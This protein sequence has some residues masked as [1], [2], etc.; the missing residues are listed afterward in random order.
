VESL[1]LLVYEQ[2]WADYIPQLSEALHTDWEIEASANSSEWLLQRLPDADAMLGLTL[3]P[4]ALPSATQLRA[5]FF[6]GA[7][8]LQRDANE[9]PEGCPVCNVYEHEI[10]I[11]EHVF[12]A[13]LRHVTRVPTYAT[14]FQSGR[15]EGTGRLGGETH[16]ECFGKTIG[17]LGFGHIGQE[18]AKR[19]L[20][21][22]MRVEAIRRTPNSGEDL[23]VAPHFLGGP[24][25]LRCVLKKSDFF[26]VACELTAETRGCLGPDELSLLK[27]ESLL[28]N[29]ARAEVIDEP[30]LFESLRANRFS[31]ALDVWY[32]YPATKA[33]IMH[34]SQYPF[35]ELPN[36][37]VTPHL[38]AWTEPTVRRRIQ[39]IAAN[40]DRL[41]RGQTLENV[42]FRGTWK[43]A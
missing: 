32:R 28:I 23:P 34:G 13:I 12:F 18:I 10:P 26:V 5:F 21:F 40:L 14:A 24:E 22:G 30:A 6:P 19:A 7:G 16:G 25:S 17:I 39:K 15:W 36:V 42:V 8:V 20:A 37:L 41:S 29:V 35:H 31:A 2:G 43:P 11:A 33:E 9:F 38:S 4:N 27:R 1:K 3:P